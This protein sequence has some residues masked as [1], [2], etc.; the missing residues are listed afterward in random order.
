ME[1]L[2]ALVVGTLCI[3]CFFIGAR[4]GQKVVKGEPIETPIETAKNAIREHQERK[5]TERQQDKLDKI[6]RNIEAYDG[7]GNGQEDV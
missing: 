2:L 6:M 4:V 7:T 5:E 1:I 3:V